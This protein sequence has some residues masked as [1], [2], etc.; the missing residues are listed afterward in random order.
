MVN[1]DSNEYPLSLKALKLFPILENLTALNSLKIKSGFIQAGV[2]LFFSFQIFFI[3]LFG[4]MIFGFGSHLQYT[5]NQCI[6]QIFMLLFLTQIIMLSTFLYVRN[7][8]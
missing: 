6:D 7:F 3:L 5:V 8:S 2:K 4:S 1:T